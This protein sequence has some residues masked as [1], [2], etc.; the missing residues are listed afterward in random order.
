MVNTLKALMGKVN[1]IQEKMVYISK[2]MMKTLRKNF[3]EMLELK[4]Q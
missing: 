3:K 4:I 1:I 2:E